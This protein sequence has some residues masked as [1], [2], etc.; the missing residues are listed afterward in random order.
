MLTMIVLLVLLYALNGSFAV[1]TV[2]FVLSWIG[3][4]F[5]AFD[6]ILKLSITLD[7][8]PTGIMKRSGRRQSQCRIFT[9]LQQE[10]AICVITPILP[11]KKEKS[12]EF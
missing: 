5:G 4:G 8:F 1:P 9:A 10:E 7:T 6:L 11:Q 12:Q 3:I 2:C